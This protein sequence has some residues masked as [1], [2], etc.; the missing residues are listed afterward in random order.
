[1]QVCIFSEKE[2]FV[3]VLKKDDFTAYENLPGTEGIVFIGDDLHILYE[4]GALAEYDSFFNKLTW[5]QLIKDC[6]DVIWR[7]NENDLLETPQLE[8]EGL[9]QWIKSALAKILGIFDIG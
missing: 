2:I 3:R 6:T 5:N 4:S 7:V 1:M 9:L 8:D